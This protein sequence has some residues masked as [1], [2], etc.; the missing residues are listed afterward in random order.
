MFGIALTTLGAYAT[1]DA[2]FF[3]GRESEEY[4][5]WAGRFALKVVSAG[6]VWFAIAAAW[7]VFGTWSWEPRQFM[8]GGPLILLTVATAVSPG[9][10]WLVV[11]AQRNGPTRLLA[12]IA[13]A[14]QFVVL[15]LNAVSRQLVQNV[16][17]GR[18][19]DVSTEPVDIQWSPLIAF[20][21]LFVL[22]LGV[23]GWMVSKVI[24]ASATPAEES[25]S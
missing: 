22:G 1:V 10:T 7:Y 5:A 19:L 2:A 16:E 4:R 14:V 11:A 15:A 18:F 17:L 13:G 12:A 3:G 23:V 8:F 24:Q 21:V 9:L 25:S 6:V 20:L